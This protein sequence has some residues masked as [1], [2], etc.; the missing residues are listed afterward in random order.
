MRRLSV[1]LASA[2]M[3]LSLIAFAV[4]TGASAAPKQQTPQ[5]QTKHF[6]GALDYSLA[7]GTLYW[8]LGTSKHAAN[9]S[10]YNLCKKDGA[11]D[12]VTQVWVY[13]G[14]VATAQSA[15]NF[16]AGWGATKHEASKAAVMRCESRGGTCQAG[17]WASTD[18]DPNKQTR[19]GYKL[20]GP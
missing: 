1:L 8:G 11:T 9:K 12:C 19:G 14:W 10:A 18:I 6:Y 7:K 2:V 4:V 15:D 20:P 16:E 13:N 17:N 5:Q 3:A